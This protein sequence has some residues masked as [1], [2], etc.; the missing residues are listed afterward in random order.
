MHKA[1]CWGYLKGPFVRWEDN[2][3]WVLKKWD[4]TVYTGSIRLGIGISWAVV[5]TVMNHKIHEIS[6]LPQEL[7]ALK[8]GLCSRKSVIATLPYSLHIKTLSL[9]LMLSSNQLHAVPTGTLHH[10]AC[11]HYYY[12]YYHHHHH[13]H[14]PS[15]HFYAG[16]LQL[17]TWKKTMFL[18]YIVLQLFWIY[19]L[20]YM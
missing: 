1:L 17:Y 12:Y 20:C 19:N 6:R 9:V 2:I 11:T 3:K 4:G 8:D 14:H 13:H 18:V 16:Y 7:P 10:Y 5:S 15:Y